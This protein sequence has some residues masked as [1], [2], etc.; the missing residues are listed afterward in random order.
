MVRVICDTSFLI[1]L[2]TRRI[3]N[4]DTFEAEIGPVRFA[5]PTC[6][7]SELNRLM[8]DPRRAPEI[9]AVLERA[10]RMDIVEMDG[11]FADG[12]IL[13]HVKQNGGIVATMDRGLKRGVKRS[14]GSVISMSRDRVVLE[15]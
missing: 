11:D 14:G 6:V 13:R 8:N 1:H 3:R 12:E 15:P 10:R 9:S 2:F 7:L 5:V 4:I